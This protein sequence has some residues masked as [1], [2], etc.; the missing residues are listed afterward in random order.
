MRRLEKIDFEYISVLNRDLIKI[1]SLIIKIKIQ[2]DIIQLI[3]SQNHLPKFQTL[4]FNSKGARVD[5][6]RGGD[7]GESTEVGEGQTAD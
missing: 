1:L 5:C 3:T 4:Q 2:P 7:F 6:L